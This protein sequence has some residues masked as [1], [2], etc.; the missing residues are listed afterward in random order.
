ML[1]A[2]PRGRPIPRAI[3]P[4]L[5]G[6]GV[7]AAVREAVGA[8]PHVVEMAVVALGGHPI[9]VRGEEVGLGVRETVDD[10]ARTFAVLLRGDRGAGVRPR[11]ARTDG[12]G[13]RRAR[14]STCCPTAR[15]RPRRWP[16]CS[17]LREHFGRLDGRRA[18][19]RRRRQ[20]RRRVARVR[21][22]R[23]RASSSSSR[24][25]PA[26]SSPDTVVDRARNL[27]GVVEQVTDPYDAVRGADAVYTDV[28]TSMGQEDEREA[29]RAAFAGYTVDDALMRGAP[30][31]R[32]CFL[33]C[34]PAHRGEEVAAEVIDGPR[35]ARVA[36]GR[37]PHARGARRCSLDLA[38]GASVTRWPRSESPNAS[39]ASARLLEEQPV[40]SQAQ[41]VQLLEADGVVATQATVSRD[42]EEL[43]AVKV[44]IPGGA[45]A[46]AIPETRK[47]RTRRPTTI[48]A[49]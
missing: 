1:D 48:C 25:R 23:C 9:Y 28:W 46:Y 41:L 34:L 42:L 38:R 14:S 17:R 35:V 16:T 3:P 33:H 32:A 36:A 29:R 45:M 13:R 39:T 20:Q 40:S 31:R 22:P 47:E 37:E 4:V 18:R 43:G 10:V 26:T 30:T 21:A 2:R 15:T 5:A 12:R 8:H 7:A 24:R 44:R 49:G 6:R 19:V 11:H 27:G